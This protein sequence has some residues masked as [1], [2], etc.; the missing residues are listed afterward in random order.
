[1]GEA[2]KKYIFQ[3]GY[4]LFLLVLALAIHSA[5]YWDY[6][7]VKTG[8]A[9]PLHWDGQFTALLL[10]SLLCSA[11]GFFLENSRLS[12]MLIILRFF[13]ILILG[14]PLG[15]Y[16]APEMYLM[17]LI[18]IEAVFYLPLREGIAFSLLLSAILLGAQKEN[19]SWAVTVSSPGRYSLLLMG[20][21]LFTVLF[22]GALLKHRTSL[23]KQSRDDLSRLDRALNKLTEVNLDYQS[24]AVRMEEEGIS[25][26]RRRISREIHDIVGYTM[27]NQL[28]IVQAVLSMENRNDTRLEGILRESKV[29]I[30]KGIAEAR[31]VLRTLHSEKTEQ[32]SP[33]T[34]IRKL[35]RTFEHLTSI[36]VN[37]DYTYFPDALDQNQT[38][39]LYR[40]I[41]EGM[42]NAFRHGMAT[43]I[44]IH[45]WKESDSW[46][47]VIE[48]N[49]R[50]AEKIVEGVGLSGMTERLA[51]VGGVLEARSL[52]SGFMVRARIPMRYGSG[53]WRE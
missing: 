53:P 5:L 9:L 22:M 25:K 46:L 35:T 47:A 10:F 30:E 31:S 15:S 36:K 45:F 48:D 49:G 4:S 43:R 7:T 39:A 14:Y 37:V 18:I 16:Y 1:M 17:G 51:E 19:Q 34:L 8:L 21:F 11:A 38:K 44:G 23:L 41:Q 24:H 20:L 6:Q 13:S 52:K 26:E 2:G 32:E 28:M 40:L 42:T 33:L 3:K 50:G 12:L 29:Q 27:T